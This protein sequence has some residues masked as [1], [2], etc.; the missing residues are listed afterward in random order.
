MATGNKDGVKG[1]IP[2]EHCFV[3][4]CF[5][6]GGGSNS[7]AGH[8]HLG[9]WAFGYCKIKMNFSEGKA[10]DWKQA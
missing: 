10:G 7:L 3:A 1:E 5:W 9:L 6:G 2:C 4:F 8:G